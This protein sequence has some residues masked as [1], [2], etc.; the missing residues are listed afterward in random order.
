[1]YT[2]IIKS[3]FPI[4]NVDQANDLNIIK[5]TAAINQ[6]HFNEVIGGAEEEF[7]MNFERMMNMVNM[8]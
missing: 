2:G 3:T 1:M 8:N 7:E 5:H 6:S 4:L